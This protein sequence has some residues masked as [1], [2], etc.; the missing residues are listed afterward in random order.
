MKITRE[1]HFETFF[2]LYYIGMGKGLNSDVGC[3]LQQHRVTSEK[4]YRYDQ[5]P[6]YCRDRD[7]PDGLPVLSAEEIPKSGGNACMA[8]PVFLQD[9]PFYI[10]GFF[11]FTIL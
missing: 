9:V 2:S 10:A 1:L 11:L 7:S 6:E 8:R 5:R 3:T 4:E